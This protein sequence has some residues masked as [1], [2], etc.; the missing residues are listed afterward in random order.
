MPQPPILHD[1]AHCPCKK[2]ECPRNKNCALC[3]ENHHKDG[4]KTTCERL[5]EKAQRG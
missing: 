5:A 3:M 1:P 4:G 2:V